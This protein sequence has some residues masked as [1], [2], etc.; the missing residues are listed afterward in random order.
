MS[1]PGAPHASVRRH[2]PVRSQRH[3]A[4]RGI[5]AKGAAWLGTLL[6]EVVESHAVEPPHLYPTEDGG[7]SAEWTFGRWEV[8][9]VF[10]LS[11]RTADLLAADVDSDDGAAAVWFERDG[12][13]ALARF[14]T[15]YAQIGAGAV[16]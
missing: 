7:I 4:G 8:S 2:S 11:A 3:G 6:R 1:H 10:H 13:K 15:S 14:I 5:S 12:V 9:A 16:S